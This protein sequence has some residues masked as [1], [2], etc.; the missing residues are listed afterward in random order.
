MCNRT[1][2]ES[3]KVLDLSCYFLKPHET[4]F[5]FR[6]I[7]L[8]SPHTFKYVR[9]IIYSVRSFLYFFSLFLP[10]IFIQNQMSVVGL[11]QKFLKQ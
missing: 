8:F 5:V 2:E 9:K 7:F 6:H 3:K 11:R 4:L 1:D 10:N